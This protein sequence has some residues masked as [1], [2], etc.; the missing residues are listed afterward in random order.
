MA[1]SAWVP[2]SGKDCNDV[3]DC[4]RYLHTQRCVTKYSG[5]AV[6]ERVCKLDCR[7]CMFSR[8]GIKG[9]PYLIIAICPL[10]ASGYT[11]DTLFDSIDGRVRSGTGREG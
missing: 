2:L 1:P 9:T 7:T 8:F 11:S 6:L 3:D 4:C 10:S 5:S